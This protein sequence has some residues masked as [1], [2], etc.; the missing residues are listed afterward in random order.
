MP[1]IAPADLGTRIY[2]EIQT[3]ITRGDDSIVIKAINSAIKE[4]K[5][6]L[7]KYDL[8]ALFGT[9]TEDPTI[10]DEFL[11]NMVKAIAV[12]HLILLANPNK[13]IALARS[14]YEDAISS[15]KKIMAGTAIPEGWPYRD[16]TGE[17]AAQGDAIYAT[18][19][20]RRSTHF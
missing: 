8:V 14:A 16:T 6:Y 2:P 3:L 17:T 4:V 11:K 15:L 19:N 9:D 5:M 20:P 7:N 18:S 13:D 12:W 10:D 1:I